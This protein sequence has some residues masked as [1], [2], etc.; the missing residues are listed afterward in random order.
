MPIETGSRRGGAT[1]E[2]TDEF[3]LRP[4]TASRVDLPAQQEVVLATPLVVREPDV[5]HI[6]AAWMDS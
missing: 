5:K 4:I 1:V 2:Y 6:D 3:Q